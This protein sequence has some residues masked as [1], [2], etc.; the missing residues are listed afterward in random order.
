[1]EETNQSQQVNNT[2]IIMK[3]KETQND[4]WNELKDTDP[5]HCRVK[6]KEGN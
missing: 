6:K 2:K 1:M 3:R 4:F 5:V